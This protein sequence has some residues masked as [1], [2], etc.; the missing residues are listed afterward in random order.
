LF[1]LFASAATAFARMLLPQAG[2]VIKCTVAAALMVGMNLAAQIRFADRQDTESTRQIVF[3]FLVDHIP[4]GR[5]WDSYQRIFRQVDSMALNK[6]TRLYSVP[7]THLTLT[8]YSGLPVQDITPV[9][10]SFLDSYRGDVVYLDL[11]PAQDTDLLDPERIEKAAAKSGHS[12][13]VQDT[14]DASV[15]LY[16]RDYRQ[17]IAEIVTP[18]E[19]PELEE[20]PTFLQPLLE[21][22]RAK[23]AEHFESS[24]FE[25]VTRGYPV[26]SWFDWVAV[27]K[28]RFAALESRRGANTNFA[29]RLRASEAVIIPRAGPT[30]IFRSRWHP[31]LSSAPVTFRIARQS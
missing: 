6:G 10:R 13:S 28:Y 7:N 25:L 31:P 9:R 12:I 24:G 26:R 21:A 22:H 19:L 3:P 18:G 30:I 8:F 16:T 15:L 1:L 23:V 4:G 29:Q 2:T 20:V 11:V 14:E 17:S 5:T 27:F